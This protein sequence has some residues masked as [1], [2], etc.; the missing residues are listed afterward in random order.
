MENNNDNKAKFF[1]QYYGQQVMKVDDLTYPNLNKLRHTVG[2]LNIYNLQDGRFIGDSVY[3]ELKPLESITDE[4][5]IEVSRILDAEFDINN[6]SEY[7]KTFH[8][9]RGKTH[10]LPT[11]PCRSDVCDY[12]R[13]KGYLLPWMGLSTDQILEYGWA[14]IKTN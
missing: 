8:V 9:N 7:Q 10:I 1:A 11:R 12:L 3:L 14:R 2:G 4:D 13:S 5:A 6:L